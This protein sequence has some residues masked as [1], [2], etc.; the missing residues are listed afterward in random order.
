[1][2]SKVKGILRNEVRHEDEV[3]PKNRVFPTLSAMVL[4][5]VFVSIMPLDGVNAS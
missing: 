2:A 1:M 3:R 5:D 4:D